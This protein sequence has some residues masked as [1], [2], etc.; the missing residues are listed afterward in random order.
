MAFFV[1]SVVVEEEVAE[2]KRGFFLHRSM[3]DIAFQQPI[4]ERWETHKKNYI[5]FT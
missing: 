5:K 4:K 2:L 3:I 1:F